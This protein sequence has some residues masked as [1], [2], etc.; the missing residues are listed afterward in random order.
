[1]RIVSK[2]YQRATGIREQSLLGV[3][4]YS[5]AL[6]RPGLPTLVASTSARRM[7]GICGV[8]DLLPLGRVFLPVFVLLVNA[9]Q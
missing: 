2:R 7:V 1:M 6:A 4:G 9:L 8:P 3:S 5:R